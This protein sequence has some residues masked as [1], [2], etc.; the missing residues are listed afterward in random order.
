MTKAIKM[1]D[2]NLPARRP[3]TKAWD[4]TKVITTQNIERVRAANEKMAQKGQNK[5]AGG[6]KGQGSTK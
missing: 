1:S 4:P 6:K 2:L 5:P 3:K